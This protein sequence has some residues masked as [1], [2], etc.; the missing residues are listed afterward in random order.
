MKERRYFGEWVQY[1]SDNVIEKEEAQRYLQLW[2]KFFLR[3]LQSELIEFKIIDS[4]DSEPRPASC[5][6]INSVI[7]A[8]ILVEADFKKTIDKKCDDISNHD[9]SKNGHC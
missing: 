4:Y 6:A 5:L 9:L 8:K 2:K 7:S 3:K 1:Q